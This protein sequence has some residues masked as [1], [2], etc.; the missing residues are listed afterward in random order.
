[1]QSVF[2][3]EK[4]LQTRIN[5]QDSN[6]NAG[7]H[8]FHIILIQQTVHRFRIHSR[9]IILNCDHQILIHMF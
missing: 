8:T 3:S 7:F 6:G 2:L 5:I 1:M 9:T 4:P